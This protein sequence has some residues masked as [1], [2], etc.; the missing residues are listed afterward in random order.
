LIYDTKLP[1]MVLGTHGYEQ[2][3]ANRNNHWMNATWKSIMVK[4]F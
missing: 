2:G 3:N 4:S 1:Y